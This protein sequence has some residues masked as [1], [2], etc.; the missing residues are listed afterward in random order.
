M[1]APIPLAIVRPVA[2]AAAQLTSSNVA[3]LHGDYD[4]DAWDGATN[5]AIGDLVARSTTHRTY[6]RRTA[7]VSAGTPESDPTNW[8]DIGATNLYKPFDR[9]Y[10]AQCQNDDSIVYTLTPGAFADCL[11]ILNAQC[12]TAQLTVAGTDFD[13]T[14]SMYGRTVTGWY[15]FFYEPFTYRA[16]YAFQNLPMLIGNVVTLTL[17]NAGGVAMVGEIVVG[18]SRAIG[19]VKWS[20]STGIKDYSTKEEDQWGNLTVLEGA[21]SKR[22]TLNLEVANTFIDE[23]HRL[24]ARYRATALVVIGVGNLYECLIAYGYLRSWENV[25]P[26][27]IKSNTNFVFEG[28]T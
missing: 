19:Y 13:E 20:P 11:V 21:Y 8:A 7:G 18:L 23:M 1:T 26:G 15:D 24:F 27:P 5:Y 10:Q 6:Q 22:M 17:T 2:I 9:V 14:A 28:L 16:D 25:I 4:A 12:A 3:E